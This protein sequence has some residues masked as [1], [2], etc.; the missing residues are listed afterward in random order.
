M[1]AARV[2][3][4]ESRKPNP[5]QQCCGNNINRARTGAPAGVRKRQLGKNAVSDSGAAQK[6]VGAAICAGRH[7]LFESRARKSGASSALSA[8]AYNRIRS[9]LLHRT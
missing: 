9:G 8:V 1:R 6:T 3:F 2:L 7:L 4:D 5:A